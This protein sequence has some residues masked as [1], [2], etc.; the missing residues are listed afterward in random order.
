MMTKIKIVW[1]SDSTECDQAGCSGGYSTGYDL[2][3]GD[4]LV[5]SFI[6]SASCYGGDTID[7]TDALKEIFAYFGYELEVDYE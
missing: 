1:T 7:E 4:E 5:K 3:V 2:F 6:P